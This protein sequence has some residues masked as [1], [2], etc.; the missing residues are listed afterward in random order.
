MSKR[1]SLM[2]SLILSTAFFAGAAH[3][4]LVGVKD[5][6]V[7]QGSGDPNIQVT[8]LQAFETKTGR[9]VALSSNGTVATASSNWSWDSFAGKA[10]DGQ[11]ANQNFPN[12]WHSS[13]GSLNDWLNISFSSAVNLDSITMYGRSECCSFRDVYN[14]AFYGVDGGLLYT[15]TLDASSGNHMGSISLPTADV[16]EPASVALLGLGVAGLMASRRKQVKK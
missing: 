11:Y 7:S 14:L 6:R 13:G 9:N 4:G 3:A 5:I 8:E 10:I 15:A 2:S 16:P 1:I 12:M